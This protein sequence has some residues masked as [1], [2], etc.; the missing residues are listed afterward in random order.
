MDWLACGL[1]QQLQ[2]EAQ[3]GSAEKTLGHK[4]SPKVGTA[5][6]PDPIDAVSGAGRFYYTASFVEQSWHL[7][8]FARRRGMDLSH[9]MASGCGFPT[10]KPPLAQASRI[11]LD[12]V[13]C[14]L[15][16]TQPIP[17]LLWRMPWQ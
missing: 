8:Q 9:K 15:S 12:R 13:N 7:L 10:G 4:N 6:E 16:N 1:R 11:G 14:L 5:A 2:R 17:F 3:H